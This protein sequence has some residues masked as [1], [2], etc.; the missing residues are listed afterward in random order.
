MDFLNKK[1]NRILIIACLV[2]CYLAVQL[3][4]IICQIKGR[5]EFNGVF[6]ALQF[7]ICLVMA[8]VDHKKGIR[9]SLFLMMI[10][11]LIVIRAFFM[12][13]GS[14]ALPGL[15]NSILYIVALILL[16][17][18]IL[19][20][21]KLAE[22]DFLTGLKNRRGLTRTMMSGINPKKSFH[23][24]HIKFDN[25]RIF[26]S[27]YGEE[28]GDVLI[29]GIGDIIRDS[30][31]SK[32]LAFRTDGSNFILI[33]DGHIDIEEYVSRLK[34]N[35]NKKIS[36]AFENKTVECFMTCYIG[37]STYPD[38]AKHPEHT[39][40]QA[41]SAVSIARDSKNRELLRYDSDMDEKAKRQSELD[42]LIRNAIE[43]EYFYMNYQPQ[44]MT[45]DKKLRGFEALLR[46]T[47]PDGT[48]IS[49][50]E[51]IPVAERRNL[52]DE[53][54]CY[55]LS[56]AMREFKQVLSE[57]STEVSVSINISAQSI[58][59]P[60]FVD[61]L[62][63]IVKK[64]NFP[65]KNLEIEITE[66]SFLN[67]MDQAIAN[68]KAIRDKGIKIALDDFGTGYTSLNYLERIPI[69]L[70]KLDKSLIDDI[71]A[72]DKHSDFIGGVV[73]IGH[74]MDCEVLA[75]GVEHD[76]QCEILRGHGC[77]MIQG[78]VWGRPLSFEE[79]RKLI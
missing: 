41:A 71:E 45:G 62:M 42:G 77:D 17:A 53:L 64:E 49:P 66:Y 19:K 48:R 52:M 78:F 37:A 32:D 34:T 4:L 39:V 16:N 18:Q 15:C 30:I 70:L 14:D 27:S 56:H 31:G 2:V 6:V 68:I 24:I 60:W 28:F 50:G 69:D 54:D 36:V 57:N 79:A 74:L 65:V 20:H 51:F 55:V 76:K 63:E 38:N 47:T 33:I 23:V 58:E 44:Y 11:F 25:F 8:T 72:S 3:A 59:S 75:E 13:A 67:S 12:G 5:N 35:L 40:N 21:E 46:L 10:S 7:A 29:V 9:V 61:K 43:N 1:S 22:T 26:V 73:K